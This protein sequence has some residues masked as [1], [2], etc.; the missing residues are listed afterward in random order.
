MNNY[1]SLEKF[2]VSDY[3][4]AID[5]PRKLCRGNSISRCHA[6]EI[7]PLARREMRENTCRIV[8]GINNRE[9]T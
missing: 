8:V 4:V 1:Y 5:R 3:E 6:S 2:S 7:Y 9:V